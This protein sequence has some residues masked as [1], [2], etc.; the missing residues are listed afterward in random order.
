MACPVVNKND[1]RREVVVH[2]GAIHFSK[3]YLEEEGIRKYGKLVHLNEGGW[4]PSLEGC[5][6]KSLSQ[7]HGV[8]IL[9]EEIYSQIQVGDL[10]GF[11]PPHS[12]LT[13][14]LMGGYLST[15]GQHLNHLSQS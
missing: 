7:E 12:C 1:S 13:A 10:L 11:L 3:D 14:D 9:S 4:S 2:G 8:V 15:E 6:L 5:Y